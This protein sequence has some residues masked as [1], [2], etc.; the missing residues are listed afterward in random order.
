MQLKFIVPPLSAPGL[1]VGE[2]YSAV[3]YGFPLWSGSQHTLVDSSSS[4]LWQIIRFANL[5]ITLRVLRLIP[6]VPPL[7]L[8]SSVTVDIL[9]C[10]GLVFVILFFSILNNRLLL[11]CFLFILTFFNVLSVNV[12]VSIPFLITYR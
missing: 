10:C 11:T 4:T 1:V 7:A 2:V 5:L 6:A 12:L 8:V 9:R 3:V